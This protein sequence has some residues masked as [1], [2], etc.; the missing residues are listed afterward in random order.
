MRK[1]WNVDMRL[2]ENKRINIELAIQ[3]LDGII[4][5]PWQVFSFWELVGKPSYRWGYLDG[6]LINHGWVS[7]WVGWGLCQLS[8]LLYWMFLH[9][10]MQIL[11][12]HRH[13]YDIF[14]DSWRVLPFAS[15]AT[16]FYNY[17]DLKVQNTSESPLQIKLWTD[18]KYLKWQIL[19]DNIRSH[20][21]HVYEKFHS[22]LY[23]RW[24]YFRYNII[25]RNK[26]KQWSVIEDIVLLKNFSPVKY[27]V[28]RNRLS[29]NGYTLEIVD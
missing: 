19:S 7:T 13:S 23:S 2:Q 5:N 20:K 27:K 4:I 11:E 9:T 22:F 8:N 12:R 18:K 26:Q 21:Y 25:A 16:I 24:E 17:V 15:G 3:K 10:D 29:E 28:D 14:P 6:I 1:L